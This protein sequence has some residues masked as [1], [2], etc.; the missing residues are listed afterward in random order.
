MS[1]CIA[2]NTFVPSVALIEE[3]SPVEGRCWRSR[4]GGLVVIA[5][6]DEF[7]GKRWVHISLSRRSRIPTFEDIAFVKAELIGPDFPAYQVFPK[8]AEH[9]NYH[10]HCLHLWAPVDHDIWPDPSGERA[11]AVGPPTRRAG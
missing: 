1:L 8:A 6:D 10:P 7:Y 11:D 2:F 3:R 9:R 4:D 5:S